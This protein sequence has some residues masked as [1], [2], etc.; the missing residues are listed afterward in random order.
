MFR[1][2][3]INS[4]IISQKWSKGALP[5]R[6]LAGFTF[7]ILGTVYYARQKVYADAPT[8]ARKYHDVHM[9]PRNDT[10]YHNDSVSHDELP[11]RWND[12]Y[13]HDKIREYSATGRIQG[14]SGIG[15]IDAV[16]IP[17][18][19]AQYDS[20]PMFLIVH[21]YLQPYSPAGFLCVIF[22]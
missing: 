16:A 18:F 21:V 2:R 11:D 6:Y 15:R 1:R 9:D 14:D 20:L 10:Q 19:V 7:A 5:G 3:S 13:Y 17:K 12:P 8:N 4:I 22:G